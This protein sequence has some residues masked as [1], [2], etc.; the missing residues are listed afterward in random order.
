VAISSLIHA[1]KIIMETR[2]RFER[3]LLET[4]DLCCALINMFSIRFALC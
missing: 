1:G 2:S 4:H 3:A